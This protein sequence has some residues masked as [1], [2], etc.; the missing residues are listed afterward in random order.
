VRHNNTEIRP[1][2]N[3]TRASNFSNER[4]GHIP[5]TLEDLKQ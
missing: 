1:M 3:P 5:L 4:K 2:N